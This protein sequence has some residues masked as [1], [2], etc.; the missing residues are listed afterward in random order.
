MALSPF[1]RTLRG[2]HRSS[3]TVLPPQHSRASRP[4]CA[5]G[6]I[7]PDV[8]LRCESP[9]RSPARECGR[10]HPSDFER[11]LGRCG[12]S[13]DSPS[14]QHT[15]L[16]ANTSARTNRQLSPSGDHTIS[17]CPATLALARPSLTWLTRPHQRRSFPRHLLPSPSNPRPLQRLPLGRHPYMLQLPQRSPLHWHLSQPTSGTRTPGSPPHCTRN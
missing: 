11:V 17:R 10:S 15:F 2:C 4:P 14:R 9:T 1:G 7:H 5:L 16:P 6:H 8:Q 12:H 13:T 3:G